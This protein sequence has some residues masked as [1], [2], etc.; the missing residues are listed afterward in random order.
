MKKM[1]GERLKNLK[2]MFTLLQ[3]MLS[4]DEEEEKQAELKQFFDDFCKDTSIPA[5][6]KTDA[7]KVK[8]LV[9]SWDPIDKWFK[10]VPGL[11][12]G[13]KDFLNTYYDEKPGSAQEAPSDD[14][15]LALL[16]AAG[17]DVDKL[18]ASGVEIDV[19]KLKAVLLSQMPEQAKTTETIPEVD[20]DDDIFGPDAEEDEEDEEER[21]KKLDQS[22]RSQEEKLK[23]ETK[24]RLIAP[25]K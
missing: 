25:K 11:S 13:M 22:L 7:E 17:I 20:E 9:E 15:N 4:S 18:Q 23:P 1:V 6:M 12:E 21:R 14:E 8:K 19:E 2:E 3:G 10:E 24:K 5:Q 16:K